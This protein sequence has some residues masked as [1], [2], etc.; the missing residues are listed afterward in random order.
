MNQASRTSVQQDLNEFE[1]QIN[2]GVGIE[3]RE[4]HFNDLS[5]VNS[6]GKILEIIFDKT[7]AFVLDFFKL[8]FEKIFAI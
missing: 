1:V 5:N 6:L 3:E 4:I 7:V 8:I 2:E